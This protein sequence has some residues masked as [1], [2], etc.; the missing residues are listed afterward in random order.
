ML[1]PELAGAPEQDPGSTPRA[2]AQSRRRRSLAQIGRTKA[3][4]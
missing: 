1:Y 2:K 4:F 3:M